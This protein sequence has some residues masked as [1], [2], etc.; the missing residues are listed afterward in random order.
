MLPIIGTFHITIGTECK[1]EKSHVIIVVVNTTL[2]IACILMTRQKLI[3]PRKSTH[4]VGVAVDAVS[5]AKVNARSEATI[6]GMG[7]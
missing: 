4:I 2:Q 5:D 3:R 6:R 1:K 7:I